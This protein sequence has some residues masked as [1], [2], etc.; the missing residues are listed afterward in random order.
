MRRL[1]KTRC[2]GQSSPRFLK[3]S[4]TLNC[5]VTMSRVSIWVKCLERQGLNLKCHPQHHAVEHLVAL[6]GEALPEEVC[7][8][9]QPLTVYNPDPLPVYSLLLNLNG[10]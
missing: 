8:T 2:G 10:M 5:S 9:G 7:Y 3:Y 6:R 4:L 1:R